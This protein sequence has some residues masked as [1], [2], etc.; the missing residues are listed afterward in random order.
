MNNIDNQKNG[1]EDPKKLE[2][3]FGDKL[4][5]HD[6]DGIK[7]LDNALPPWWVILFYIT[8]NFSFIYGVLYF[9]V[10]LFGQDDE[11]KKEYENAQYAIVSYKEEQA[12]ILVEQSEDSTPKVVIDESNV[13]LDGS[14]TALAEGKKIYVANC[15]SCHREDGGGGIGANL[16]DS[17]WIHGGEFRDIFKL[18]KYGIP[19]KGMIAWQYQLTPEQL[20]DVT[21]YIYTILKDTDAP[22]GKKPENQ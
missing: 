15:V 20:R 2:E 8:I 17:Y 11:L 16:T 21:S 6:Y 1:S 4:L 22:N 9:G 13:E 12:R 19:E 18:I 7:E 5:D 10:G 14:E 3:E